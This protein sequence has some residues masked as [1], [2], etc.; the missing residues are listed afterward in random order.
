[1]DLTKTLLDLEQAGWQAQVD[2]T[3][4]SFYRELL[5]SDAVVIG[6]L[7]GVVT[8]DAAV[9][10]LAGQGWSWFRLR[11]PRLVHLG[12]QAAVLT[13]RVIARRDFDTEY[14]ALVTSVYRRT[15]Q[16]W[17]VALVQHTTV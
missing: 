14:Q 13:C 10:A 1:M 6:V 11:G 4:H 12:D 16:R 5:T 15:D 9:D 7:G 8:G 3:A 2:G 17:T